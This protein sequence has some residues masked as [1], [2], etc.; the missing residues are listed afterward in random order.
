[1][2]PNRSSASAAL[3]RDDGARACDEL[4]AQTR[5]A[6]VRQEA[7]PCREAILGL[8]LP[9]AAV[10]TDARV[11]LTSAIAELSHGGTAFL[12]QTAGRL[13]DLRRRL[14]GDPTRPAVRLHARGLT[15][16]AIFTL[17]LLVIIAGLGWAI[18][19]GLMH[20]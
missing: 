3:A 18:A 12:D 10:V 7:K 6:L 8:E 1:M 19:I 16:R 13:A 14:P 17:Y 11:Y 15:M 2:R 9:A 5:S 4:T 20:Q